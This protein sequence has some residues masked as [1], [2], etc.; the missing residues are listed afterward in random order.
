[1]KEPFVLNWY[2]RSGVS[3]AHESKRHEREMVFGC[4]YFDSWFFETYMTCPN[5]LTNYKEQVNLSTILTFLLMC[6]VR[7]FFF[8]YF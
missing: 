6:I 4:I 5:C 8:S 1:M 7:P 2:E 3:E